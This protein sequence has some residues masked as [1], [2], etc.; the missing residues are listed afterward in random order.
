VG[1]QGRV[2]AFE[3]NA[4]PRRKLE[5]A[6]AQAQAGNVRVLPLALGRSACKAFL[7][8][9]PHHNVGRVVAAR[10]PGTLEVDMASLDE[11]LV[12][13]AVAGC[14]IDVEGHE[15]EVI[16]GGLQL[17]A[18]CRPW[19]CVEF[20][21]LLDRNDRLGLWKVHALLASLDY[22]PHLAE[23][24]LK[25]AVGEAVADDARFGGY[26]NL[27]YLPAERAGAMLR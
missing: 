4:T 20:N 12:E 11:Q 1:A 24:L 27:F 5:A 14:K 26:R 22:R 7:D 3:P 9:G 15:L 21:T 6:L 17:L 23:A 18:R 10:H 8:P 16:G 13:V 25:G 2:F 19:L